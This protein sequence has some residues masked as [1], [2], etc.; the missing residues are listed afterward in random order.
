MNCRENPG[1][2]KKKWLACQDR[3][4]SSDV[5][6]ILS[7]SINKVQKNFDAGALGG[8]RF[9]GSKKRRIPRENVLAF[10]EKYGVPIPAW[11][12]EC[13][14]D[15]GKE[16]NTLSCQNTFELGMRMHEHTVTTIRV[17]PCTITM[18]QEK[19]RGMIQTT[20]KDH[21][22]PP[23]EIIFMQNGSPKEHDAEQ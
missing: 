19:F 6:R 3:F 9:P 18:E 21:C 17:H 22:Y 7:I 2:G 11:F 4:S 16:V 8:Y 5:S 13:S 15:L 12:T 1:F 20:C 14:V 23:P 10:A